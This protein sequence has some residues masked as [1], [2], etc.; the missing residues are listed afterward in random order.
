MLSLYFEGI[1]AAVSPEGPFPPSKRSERAAGVQRAEARAFTVGSAYLLGR[2]AS[3]G[4]G[5]A[6]PHPPTV[7]VTTA[8]VRGSPQTYD[9]HPRPR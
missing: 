8:A 4:A 5:S 1:S 7:T 6:A 9:N 2:E 3:S